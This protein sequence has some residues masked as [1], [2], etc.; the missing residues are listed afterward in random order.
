MFQHRTGSTPLTLMHSA[1][2]GEAPGMRGMM[3]KWIPTET[4]MATASNIWRNMMA[5]RGRYFGGF[6]TPRARELFWTQ[7][8]EFMFFCQIKS[9][10]W[11]RTVP[12]SG[13]TASDPLEDF[14]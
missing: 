6:L 10:R 12:V 8:A 3:P 5:N 4:Y 1:K 7:E 9:V 11:L 14:K 13:Q 2:F